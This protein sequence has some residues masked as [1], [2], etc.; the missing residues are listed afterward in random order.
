MMYQCTYLVL[1]CLFT[2]FLIKLPLYIFYIY[3]FSKWNQLSLFFETFIVY[4][5]IF[6]LRNMQYEYM[7]E[8]FGGGKLG[9]RYHK[10]VYIIYE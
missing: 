2:F 5:M 10:D 7:D 1:G 9:D 3:F 8:S 4:N 6:L